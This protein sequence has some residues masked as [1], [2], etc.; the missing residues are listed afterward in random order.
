MQVLR[1]EISA[2]NREVAERAEAVQQE[3]EKNIELGAELLTL[4]NRRDLLQ[5]EVDGFA[6]KYN[7]VSDESRQRALLCEELQAQLAKAAA[8]S[9]ARDEELFELKKAC[10]DTDIENKR[11]KLQLDSAELEQREKKLLRRGST[12]SALNAEGGAN[13]EKYE[14]LLATNKKYSKV[15]KALE[16]SLKRT[17]ADLA[18][19]QSEKAAV[20]A[21]LADIR[22]KYRSKLSS[23]LLHDN[24]ADMAAYKHFHD[25]KHGHHSHRKQSSMTLGS[26]KG[27][28]SHS[29]T[30]AAEGG[31][32]N[33]SEETAEQQQAAAQEDSAGGKL[34]ARRESAAVLNNRKGST[35]AADVATNVPPP[36]ATVHSLSTTAILQ[37]QLI[38]SYTQREQLNG[39][40]LDASLRQKESMREAYRALYDKYRATLENVE[41]Y[42]PVAAAA[43]VKPLEEQLRF[44]EEVVSGSYSVQ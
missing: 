25:H 33:Q 19:T 16:K 23:L 17:Q 43:R 29:V 1:T 15:V 6:S 27:G 13:T 9:K 14:E 21:E 26:L 24:E 39:T 42:L 20:A 22:E 35:V 2:L 4:V 28:S 41:E 30:A 40:Q 31:P 34:S 5:A 7:L 12:A 44:G 18:E 36:P 8:D 37:Q 10:A 38:D 11:I 32:G 3:K